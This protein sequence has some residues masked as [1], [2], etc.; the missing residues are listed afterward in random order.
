MQPRGRPSRMTNQPGP[1]EIRTS[2]DG[3]IFRITIDNVAKRNA[4]SPGMMGQLS[5]ALTRYDADDSLWVAVLSAEGEHFTAGLDMP[6][7]F[8]P[9]ATWKGTPEGNVD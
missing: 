3:R 1:G 8:G 4:F 7:F 6:K 2:T 9:G 5:E